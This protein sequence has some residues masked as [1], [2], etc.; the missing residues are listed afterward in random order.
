M[1][2]PSCWNTVPIT[3]TLAHLL[4][5]IGTFKAANRLAR[6]FFPH[7]GS[8]TQS[9]SELNMHSTQWL[10]CLQDKTR[11]MPCFSTNH[12]SP[13]TAGE[14]DHNMHVFQ[15]S[16]ARMHAAANWFETKRGQM[17]EGTLTFVK[18]RQQ[19]HMQ[20]PTQK[21]SFLT[22]SLFSLSSTFYLTT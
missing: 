5:P 22:P 6:V 4:A 21:V 12:A 9:G 15:P 16:H 13:L 2:A 7:S 10:R 20:K 17:L 19:Q 18:W 3:A 14:C 8:E 1:E 11:K